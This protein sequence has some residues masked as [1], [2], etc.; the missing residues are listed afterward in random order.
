MALIRNLWKL[1]HPQ[2]PGHMEGYTAVVGGSAS[3]P[4][5]LHM[6]G[7]ESLGQP[8]GVDLVFLIDNSGSMKPDP[9][10][11]D[12][13]GER[14]AAVQVLSAAFAPTRDPWDRIAVIVFRNGEAVL[15]SEADP[16]KSWSELP[17]LIENI[18]QDDPIGNTPMDPGMARATQLLA[19]QNGCYKLVILLSDGKPTPDYEDYPQTDIITDQRVP[20]AFA[21]R[22]LYSTVYLRVPVPDN[23]EPVDSALLK[24]IARHTD[25][26]TRYQHESDPPIYYFRIEDTAQ[27]VQAYRGLFDAIKNRRVPLEVHLAERVHPRLLLDPQFPPQFAGD[28]FNRVQNVIGTSLDDALDNFAHPENDGR[29]E[30]TLNELKGTAILSFAVKLDLETVAPE[31]FEQGYVLL[32]V[33]RPYP[34]SKLR[35]LEPTAGVGSLPIEAELPQAEIKFELGLQVIKSLEQDGSLVNIEIHNLDQS[36][37]KWFELLEHPSG[38]VNPVDFEDDFG[39]TPLAMLYTGRILPW[40]KRLIPPDL[41]P[42]PGPQRTQLFNQVRQ[43]LR[44]AHAPFLALAAEIDPL[45]G[46]FATHDSPYCVDGQTFWNTR[47]V[48]GAYRLA[49]SLPGKA[50]RYLRFRVE[51]ASFVKSGEVVRLLMAPVDAL[52]LKEGDPQLSIYL[53]QGFDEPKEVLPNPLRSQYAYPQPRPDL[54]VSTGLKGHEWKQFAALFRGR[55][56]QGGVSPWDLLDSPDI[57]PFWQHNADAIGVQINIC[58]G[59][60]LAPAGTLLKVCTYFLPFTGAEFSPP[61]PVSPALVGIRRTTLPQIPHHEL[62][63]SLALSLQFSSLRVLG[64][65]VPAEAELLQ[66]VRKALAVTVVAISPAEGEVMLA[67][68]R[69]TEIVPIEC[70]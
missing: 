30:I 55:A 57:S 40:F 20:E 8:V 64:T 25:Y 52:T 56:L 11:S 27:M 48:R 5:E 37:V 51:D 36:P 58:N 23:P 6:E 32:P 45:L 66:Q 35:W 12:P 9:P 65:S 38:F 41:L 43:A 2:P 17:S 39:F 28:G 22:V 3:V 49:R 7:I 68:N 34:E 29:F 67:N 42:P 14:F 21:S 54:Y 31:D 24:Y 19:A 1:T 70:T 60:A 63:E 47:E 10:H 62:D 61:Y 53:A 26:I 15:A 69:A 13:D 18:R 46:Q 50:S 33:D 4:V 16:W 44:N 59:G